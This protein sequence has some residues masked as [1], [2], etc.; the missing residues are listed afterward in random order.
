VWQ[1]KPEKFMTWFELWAACR[2]G[3]GSDAESTAIS[4]LDRFGKQV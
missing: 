4:A 1:S 3:N 2:D